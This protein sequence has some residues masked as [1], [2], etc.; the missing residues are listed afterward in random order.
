VFG[1][2]NTVSFVTNN[3]MKSPQQFQAIKISVILKFASVVTLLFSAGHML[4]GRSSWS[5]AG[6]TDTLQ[7]MRHY[8]MPVSGVSRSYYEFYVGFGYSLSVYMLLQAV[9]LWLLARLSTQYPQAA[10]PFVAALLIASLVHAVIAAIYIFPLP[11]IFHCL[12]ACF[13]ALA[14][15]FSLK[16]SNQ[17]DKIRPLIV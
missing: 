9:L 5:P 1:G 17:S 8:K 4:G 2:V 13:L 12:V 10:R 14:L 6:E 15:A 11:A 3:I 16:A 7:A